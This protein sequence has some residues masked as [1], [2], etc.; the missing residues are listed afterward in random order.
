MRR[1]VVAGILF[2]MLGCSETSDAKSAIDTGSAAADVDAADTDDPSDNGALDADTPDAG[3]DTEGEDTSDESTG[4]Q[5]G[6]AD[7][8]A[9]ADDAD[10]AAMT[11]TPCGN[12]KKCAK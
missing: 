9:A 5:S 12:T 3:T 8:T 2:Q 10:T 11:L 7:D 4:G 6:D 1:W